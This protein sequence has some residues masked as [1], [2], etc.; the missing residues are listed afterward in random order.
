MSPDELTNRR[1]HIHCNYL[2]M[3]CVFYKTGAKYLPRA[4]ERFGLGSGPI[5]LDHLSCA[6]EELNIFACPRDVLGLHLC[7]HTMDAGV[8]CFGKECPLN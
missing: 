7:D 1:Y 4:Y 6:G 3:Y 2:V 5:F 8:Q